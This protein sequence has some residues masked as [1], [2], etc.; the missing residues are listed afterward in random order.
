MMNCH[1]IDRL[2]IA[3]TDPSA[4]PAEARTHA[5]SCARCQNLMGLE[6]GASSG[7]TQPSFSAAPSGVA[8]AV[9]EDLRPVTPLPGNA[10]LTLILIAVVVVT[11]ALLL[12]IIGAQGFPVMSNFQRIAFGSVLIAMLFVTAVG[13]VKRLVPGSLLTIPV[14]PALAVLTTIFAA[15][16]AWQFHRTYDIPMGAANLQCYEDGVV[17]AGL[18]FLAGW[19][20]GRRGFLKGNRAAIETLCLLSAA[21]A[22]FMLTIHCPLQNARHVLIGHGGAFLTAIG[23]GLAAKC[24][25]QTL[26][27]RRTRQSRK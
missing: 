7:P 20:S 13:Y 4:W 23:A 21:T 11:M 5:E 6:F 24:A 17:G 27:A 25:S 15:L 22:L 26:D 14:Q 19:W 3:G 1:D 18:T 12:A 8:Q 10:A 9:L 2:L 16:V